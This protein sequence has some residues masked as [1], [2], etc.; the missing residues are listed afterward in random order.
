[1]DSGLSAFFE[2]IP[3][4]LIFMFCGSGLGLVAV[5]TYMIVSRNRKA[6]AA[7]HNAALAGA[8]ASAKSQGGFMFN[9]SAPTPSYSGGDN[10]LPDLDS[11]LSDD[12]MVNDLPKTR[13]VS[14]GTY[15]VTLADGEAVEAVEV[16]T[17][18]RDVAEGGLLIQIGDKIYRNPPAFADSEF[19]RRFNTTVTDLARSISTI[20]LPPATPA[21]MPAKPI[22]QAE[23]KP[24]VSANLPPTPITDPVKAAAPVPGDLPKFSMPDNPTEVKRG[25][26]VPLPTQPIPDIDIGG[27]VEAYLQHK[28]RLT[29]EYAGRSIH[30]RIDTLGDVT[31]EVDGRFFDSV[32]AVDDDEVREYLQATIEEWQ[33]RQ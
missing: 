24:T 23:S 7:L 22:E 3:V 16:L 11:L 14:S 9:A 25:R 21:S 17:I 5:L 8:N 12:G 33:S 28:L 30:I 15:S 4:G 6:T 1:M 19:K 20:K 13:P 32:G 2:Q 18:L 31:I 29:P 27:S 10:D 26:R